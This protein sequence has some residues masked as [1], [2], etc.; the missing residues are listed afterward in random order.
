MAKKNRY[1][2]KVGLIVAIPLPDGRFA[3]AKVFNDNFFGVYSLVSKKIEPLEKIIKHDITFFQS[4]T[5]SAVILGE[6]PIVGEDPFPNEESAWA[7]PQAAGNLPQDNLGTPSPM[8]YYKGKMKS[9]KIEDL[10]GLDIFSACPEPDLFI[11]VLV[12]RLIKGDHSEYRV[13]L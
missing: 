9:A 6:W 13:R 8:L 4:A 11:D 2:C 1:K 12:D 10:I 3:F 7:P 5:H